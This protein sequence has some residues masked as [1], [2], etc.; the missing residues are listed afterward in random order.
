MTGDPIRRENLD[1][2]THRGKRRER[3]RQTNTRRLR[4]E[5]TNDKLSREDEDRSFP[6]GSQNQPCRCL[7]FGLPA[8]KTRRKF[9]S[10]V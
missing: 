7:D 5:T 10:T 2:F 1:I 9:I 3:R 8:S 6:K 4:E